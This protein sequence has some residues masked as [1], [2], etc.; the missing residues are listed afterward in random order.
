ESPIFHRFKGENLYATHPDDARFIVFLRPPTPL[1]RQEGPF[2]A[3]WASMAKAIDGMSAFAVG[4]A[5]L[6]LSR[7]AEV[8]ALLN[9]P[10]ARPVAPSAVSP[11]AAPEPE[12]APRPDRPRPPRR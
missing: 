11:A 8:E 4:G 10:G 7:R 1:G 6:P 2:E 5:V 9:P 3:A 12:Q